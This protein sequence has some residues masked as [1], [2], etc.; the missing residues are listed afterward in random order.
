MLCK[1]QSESVHY[2]EKPDSNKAQV[3]PKETRVQNR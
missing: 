3:E 1:E 2:E